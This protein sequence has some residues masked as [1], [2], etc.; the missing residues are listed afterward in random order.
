MA[1]TAT[2]SYADPATI[3]ASD[4]P[5]VKPWSKVDADVTSFS[6]TAVRRLVSDM[7]TALVA[8]PAAFGVDKSGFALFENV[9][10]TERAFVDEEA[11]RTSY[12]AEV[13]QLL[14]AQLPRPEQS[15]QPVARVVIF[16]HTVR[17]RNPE[18]PR[19][20]VQQIH[21]DQTP[22]AAEQRARRHLADVA[23]VTDADVD[24]LLRG[25]YQIINVW[26]PIG[27]AA[28]DTPLA[29]VDWRSTDPDDAVAVDLLYPAW[30]A[31]RPGGELLPDAD[32]AQSTDGYAIRGETYTVVPNEKHRFYYAKDMTPNSVLFIKCFDSRSQAVPAGRPGVAAWTPHTA[33]DDPATPP[34]SKGRQSIEVRCLVFYEDE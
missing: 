20:P 24:R 11:I 26:R 19:Q 28:S 34:E 33:F 29:L 14:R 22:R 6:R 17:R 32:K 21:V 7:R 10:A 23:G 8:D 18:A 15:G 27:H 9:P 5:F 1:T 4:E 16:D 30:Q 2:F 31:L 25:R 13:E 3:V 12:Y